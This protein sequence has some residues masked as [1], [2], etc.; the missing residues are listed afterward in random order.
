MQESAASIHR[1]PHEPWVYAQCVLQA[2]VTLLPKLGV[3]TVESG[4]LDDGPKVVPFEMLAKGGFAGEVR[5]IQ[6]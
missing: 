6:S 3:G 2:F 1:V 5:A 4:G